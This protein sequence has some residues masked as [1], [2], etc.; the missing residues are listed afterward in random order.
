MK[1]LLKDQPRRTPSYVRAAEQIRARILSGQLTPG[2]Q[3]PTENDLAA[4][5]KVS[6]TTAREALR[7]L[8]SERL[9]E[10]RRGVAGGVFVVHPSHSDVE[11]SMNTA[12]GLMA[13]TG[14]LLVEEVLEAWLMLGPATAALAAERR[15]D[16]E[17]ERL[18]RMAEPLPAEADDEAWVEATVAFSQ[19]MLKMTRNRL[20]PLLVRPLLTVLPGRL[21]EQRNEQGWWLR[22]A[23]EHG[24]L[25]AAIQRRDARQAY[26]TM[27][28]HV[29]KYGEVRL[30][31]IAAPEP[32]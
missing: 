27:F 3:L 26:A 18:L 15:T 19:L 21:R 16:E 7:L 14:E 6:R 32:E 13:S 30:P 29:R 31:G 17:A 2:Q 28:R 20:L 1:E 24:Q 10:T 11:A 22:N 25:A 8:A 5:L 23:Q 12:L 9:I 4:A